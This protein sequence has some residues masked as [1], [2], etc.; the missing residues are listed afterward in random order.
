MSCERSLWLSLRAIDITHLWYPFGILQWEMVPPMSRKNARL[1]KA[2]QSRVTCE[3]WKDV[4]KKAQVGH[5]RHRAS[6]L[7]IKIKKREEAG[8]A[9][10]GGVSESPVSQLF[11]FAKK[12]KKL[13]TGWFLT[14]FRSVARLLTVGSWLFFYSYSLR[15]GGEALVY[16]SPILG[17]MYSVFVSFSSELSFP[18][19]PTAVS[20][21]KGCR[22]IAVWFPRVRSPG[23]LLMG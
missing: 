5:S 23:A 1:S 20:C 13:S 9:I 12:I 21:R 19:L 2:S 11:L 10:Y 17:F 7:K 4:S 15:K 22:A 8:A 3:N 18:N 6:S 14:K 16:Y